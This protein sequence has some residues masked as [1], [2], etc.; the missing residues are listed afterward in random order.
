LIAI[1]LAGGYGTRLQALSKNLPKPLLKV[2]GRPVLD[3]VFDKLAELKDVRHVIIS[4]NAR[5]QHHFAEWLESNPQRMA[6][7]VTDKSSSEEKPGALASLS[8]IVS[9]VTDD[10]L[11]IA[12]DNLFTSSLK[13]MIHMF[14]RKSCAIV[15]LYDLNDHEL[16]KQYSTALTNAHGRIMAYAEKP[17]NPETTLVGTCIY[18][19]P[20]RTLK[21]VEEYLIETADRDNPG[22]FIAWL[23]N[24]E[25]VYGH[26]LDGYW[27]DIGTT[28][29]YYEANQILPYFKEAPLR[30]VPKAED[31]RLKRKS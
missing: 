22:G 23:C 7:I 16:A 19:L 8:Q 4:T 27:C 30:Q 12:G 17:E 28:A 13:P 18:I 21:R 2:G 3:Y 31:H 29:Q 15:A 24:R 10:C 1:V 20:N 11:I 26:I 6:L 25:P 9:Q 5:F 14:K